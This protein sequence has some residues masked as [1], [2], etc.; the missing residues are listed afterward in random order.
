[1]PQPEAREAVLDLFR[2]TG[3]YLAGHFRLT[4]GL[5]SPAYLQCALVLQHPRIAEDLGRRLAEAIAALV[6]TERI[7]V[8]ASPPIRGLIIGHAIAAALG[9]R[10]IFARPDKLGKQS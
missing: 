7:G 10:F 6:E 2:S 8:V 9:V 5:H 1:M 3:A 4:S